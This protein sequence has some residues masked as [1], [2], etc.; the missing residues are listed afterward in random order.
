MVAEL[1]IKDL[2]VSVEG[3]EILKGFDLKVRQGEIHA[4]MGPNASGKSTLSHTIMGHPRYKVEK[5]DILLNGESIL[6]LSPD[7]R[8]KRGLFLAFQYPLEI[9]GVSLANFLRIAYNNMRQADKPKDMNAEVVSV[10]KFREILKEKL[11]LL[12]MDESFANRYLNEGFSGGEKKKCEI[13]QMAILRPKI[14]VLDETDSGLD[15][16]ALKTVAKGINTLSH[17]TGILFI[18]HYQ[19]VLRYVRPNYVH[20]LLDGRIVKSGKEELAL[21]LEEKGYDWIKKELSIG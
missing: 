18:T 5:G 2:Y 15:I 21:E 10:F 17:D 1:E 14:A 8:A 11:K 19:R 20:I 4:L 7:E 16:D 13:L 9:P 6:R 3:K 12:K